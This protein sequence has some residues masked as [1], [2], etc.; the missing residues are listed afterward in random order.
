MRGKTVTS[1]IKHNIAFLNVGGTGSSR[2]KKQQQHMY[3]FMSHALVAEMPLA[4]LCQ[5]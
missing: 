1:V 4:Y 5:Q 3:E 2:K